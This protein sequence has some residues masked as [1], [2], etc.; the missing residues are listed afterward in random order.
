ML[1]VLAGLPLSTAVLTA[2]TPCRTFEGAS[3]DSLRNRWEERNALRD[4]VRQVLAEAG[5]LDS[6]GAVLVWT[7]GSPPQLKMA[8]VNLDPPKKA[9]YR[10]R[11]LLAGFFEGKPATAR[12]VAVD[13]DQPSG[14]LPADRP[15][16]LCGGAATNDDRL[17]E[18]VGKVVRRH[19]DF[20]RTSLDASG[21][22]R[23]FVDWQGNVLHSL[24]ADSTGDEW[25]DQAL[26]PLA[27][28]MKFE[29]SSLSGVPVGT[30][31]LRPIHFR[32]Q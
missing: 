32:A 31:T 28:E 19:P 21:M 17:R 3:A 10:I 20:G 2:Q 16:S 25:F 11:G 12:E 18:L 5:A 7:E 6:A 1:S 30:W 23:I 27:R 14:P 26:R 24:V 13:L 22:V 29:P 8:L 4:S 15:L 9:Y